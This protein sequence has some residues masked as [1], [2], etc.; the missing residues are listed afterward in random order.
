MVYFRT[1]DRMPKRHFLNFF[2]SSSLMWHIIGRICDHL[3][4][5]YTSQAPC[6]KLWLLTFRKVALGWHIRGCITII[7]LECCI[8]LISGSQAFS[9]NLS[10]QGVGKSQKSAFLLRTIAPYGLHIS[11]SLWNIML[12]CTVTIKKKTNELLQFYKFYSIIPIWGQKPTDIRVCH[13]WFK[14]IN[15]TRYYFKSN[16]NFYL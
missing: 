6:S 13:K 1:R 7:N 12:L 10:H 8:T 14:L 11:P 9:N 5:L 2:L 16:S 4:V 3:F 15:S